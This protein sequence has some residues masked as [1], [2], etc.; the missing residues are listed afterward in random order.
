MPITK[1]CEYCGEAFTA[2]RNTARYCSDAHKRRAYRRR[3]PLFNSDERRAQA[4]RKRREWWLD[5]EGVR[6]ELQRL[7]LT[8]RGSVGPTECNTGPRV[9]ET[10]PRCGDG[11]VNWDHI[12]DA[13][14]AYPARDSLSATPTY[15]PECDWPP[16]WR[17]A[18]ERA[19]RLLALAAKVAYL[20]RAFD[21][22]SANL[23]VVS[24]ARVVLREPER[25][26]PAALTSE[27][28]RRRD[29]SNYRRR[30]LLA[31]RVLIAV[32]AESAPSE[33]AR[34]AEIR[35]V[36]DR[37]PVER[38]RVSGTPTYTYTSSCAASSGQRSPAQTRRGTTG[39]VGGRRATAP[40]APD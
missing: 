8:K 14:D 34:V 21:V 17:S 7:N 6:R 20:A 33:T 22:E 39:A 38:L 12:P 27:L 35:A 30:F 24:N 9:A 28:H 3:D 19:L 2:K 11:S 40:G 37:A 4:Q 32:T 1:N 18:F 16:H 15:I 5:T 31:R 13:T 26:L 25:L 23:R 36:V 10:T 29:T